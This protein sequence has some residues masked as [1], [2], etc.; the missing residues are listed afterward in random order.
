MPSNSNISH[1]SEPAAELNGKLLGGQSPITGATVQLYA[2]GSSGYGTG[3][4]ALLSPAKT[5]DQNGDF[6]IASSDYTCPQP[7]TPTYLVATG[8]DPGVGSNNPAIALMVATGPCSGLSSI[9]FVN[10]DEVT[11]VASVWAL[12]PFLGYGAQVGASTTNSVGLS[13]AFNNVNNITDI[14][15]GTSPGSTAPT[16]AVIPVAKLYTLANILAS[17]V[18]S[19]GATACDALFAPATPPGGTAPTNTLDAALNI[20]R[21]PSNNAAALFSLPTPQ[22][23]FVPTLASAPSDWTISVVYKGGGLD[24]PASIAV[25]AA[26]NL[27]TANVCSSTSVCSSVTELSNTGQPRSPSSG[28]TDTPDSFFQSW[29]LAIDPSGNVWVTNE[30]TT[31]VNSGHGG[32]AKLNGSGQVLS[33]SQGYFGGGVDFPYAIAADTD[34]SVWIANNGDS[35]VSKLHAD[36]SAISPSPGGW[37]A[38]Q[39]SSPVA[40]AIDASHNAWFANNAIPGYVTSISSDGTHIATFASG[41]D[42]PDGIATDAIGVATSTSK[43]HVWIANHHTS[44]APGSVSEFQLNNDGTVTTVSNGYTGGGI[45]GPGGIAIDGAG[46]VW[47]ANY[48][49]NSL[50]E[51]EAANGSNP[52]QAISPGTGYGTDANL[53]LP[54]GVAID[55]SG[56]IWLSNY[57]SS[58]ITQFLGLAAPVKTPLVGPPQLP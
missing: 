37:G 6:S 31:S 8:G 17:C 45:Y 5:T 51:L 42:Q 27:W 57:G 50:S 18:N 32:V 29:G 19:S 21:Y 12:A 35:S 54:Y 13:N 58:T 43:G 9:S 53:R 16:G 25:D 20:A 24:Y 2:A 1:P 44:S 41:G 23:P 38:S 36:G 47:V 49:G 3:A 48:Y 4:Q 40:V 15:N 33:P 28:Y 52:G 46:S 55:S 56:N 34:G 39:L 22:A 26:G 14:T 30:Q 11:T 7:N 10:I